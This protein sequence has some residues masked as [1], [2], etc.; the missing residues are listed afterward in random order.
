MNPTDPSVKPSF[1][2]WRKSRTLS[3]VSDDFGGPMPSDPLVTDGYDDPFQYYPATSVQ[4]YCES[5][6]SKWKAVDD[7]RDVYGDASFDVESKSMPLLGRLWHKVWIPN[8]KIVL[9]GAH[10]E[11]HYREWRGKVYD[12][13]TAQFQ[14]R[15]C[16]LSARGCTAMKVFA[17]GD[18]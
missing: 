9:N 18:V 10:W 15:D 12:F 8:P 2:E 13:Y 11:W 5:C 6:E 4:A 17:G 7:R 16:D 14:P 1:K 3:E